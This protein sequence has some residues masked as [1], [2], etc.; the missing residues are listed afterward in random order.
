[1]KPVCRPFMVRWPVIT[2]KHRQLFRR[3]VFKFANGGAP[4]SG[5]YLP[6][7]KRQLDDAF[8]TLAH[9]PAGTLKIRD[10]TRH[11][12]AENGPVSVDLGPWR[13][14]KHQQIQLGVRHG[15]LPFAARAEGGVAVTAGLERL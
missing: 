8:I 14:L 9:G 6:D 7:I 5:P 2:P 10:K 3:P 11:Q 4:V 15:A 1:M 12:G 13:D